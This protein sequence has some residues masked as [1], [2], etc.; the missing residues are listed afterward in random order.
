MAGNRWRGDGRCAPDECSVRRGLCVMRKKMWSIVLFNFDN[1]V[2]AV[3]SHWYKNGQ[4][5]WPKKYIKNKNKYI[6]RRTATN[7]LEFDFYSARKLNTEKAIDS[8]KE[9]KEKARRA[10]ITSDLSSADEQPKRN[11]DDSD[12]TFSPHANHDYGSDT[13][14]VINTNIHDQNDFIEWL[15]D[16]LVGNTDSSSVVMPVTPTKNIASTSALTEMICPDDITSNN[17]IS[18]SIAIPPVTPT[19]GNYV[20][21]SLT[22]Q[23]IENAT[24]NVST[25]IN[26]SYEIIWPVNNN[27]E[28]TAIET[29]LNDQKIRNNEV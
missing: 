22:A 19:S 4:C 16:D 15:T 14:K 28:L 8:F 23:S 27:D 26:T 24:S 6:E 9:A 1:S 21:K 17:P 13:E 7:A 29:L 12:K 18:F 25:E 3:P 2:A 20:L 11:A 5:A 10:Q